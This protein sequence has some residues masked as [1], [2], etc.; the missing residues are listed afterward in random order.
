[1]QTWWFRTLVVFIIV[2][3]IVFYIKWR[4]RALKERQKDLEV[5]IDVATFV[6]KEQK[7]LVEEKHKEITDSINYARSIQQSLIP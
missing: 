7:H 1:W 2:G 6:I 5:K 4:E 3:S